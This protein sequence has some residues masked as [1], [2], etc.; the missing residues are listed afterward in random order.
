[1]IQ[2]ELLELK[3]DPT[4]VRLALHQAEKASIKASQVL[5][6]AGPLG[7]KSEEAFLTIEK[8]FV[9]LNVNRGHVEMIL[10]SEGARDE[11][12]QSLPSAYASLGQT[13]A[14]AETNIEKLS[15]TVVN[16]E[17]AAAVLK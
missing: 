4:Q 5:R 13:F 7:A 1:M 8:T 10:G 2:T 6:A 3:E 9:P 14:E 11:R 16:L 15:A 12:K 17:S